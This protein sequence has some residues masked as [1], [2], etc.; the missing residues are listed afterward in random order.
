[1]CLFCSRLNDESLWEGK[2][3]LAYQ[4]L[5][6]YV[7]EMYDFLDRVVQ[8]LLEEWIAQADNQNKAA[9]LICLRAHL[10]TLFLCLPSARV[11]VGR[12]SCLLGVWYTVTLHC[13]HIPRDYQLLRGIFYGFI[14]YDLPF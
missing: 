12:I 14:E 1:M 6:L 10:A 7:D 3:D 13:Y 5:Y 8:P 4:D 9:Y 11:T 2:R